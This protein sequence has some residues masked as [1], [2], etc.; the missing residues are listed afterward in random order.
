MKN[1]NKIMLLLAA[2]VMFSWTALGQGTIT[3]V[4]K[5]A[6]TG[7]ALVGTSI[8]LKGTSTGTTTGIDGRF[9]LQAPAYGQTLV[10][11]FIGYNSREITVNVTSG[12]ITNVGIIRLEGSAIGL[13][14]I[15][16]IADRAKERETP[17]AFSNLTKKQIEDQLGSQD[18]PLVLNTTP[19]VYATMQGGGAGDARV[20]VRGFNQRNVAIMINGVPINDMENGWV[21]WSNWDGIGDAT[22]SIQVQ[23]GLS[24][25]NLATPSIGGTMNVITSPAEATAGVTY[26]QEFGS[27]RFYK[28]TVFGHTG[29]I[30]GKYAISAGVVRKVGEG[31]IDATYTDAWAYYLGASYNINKKNRIEFY[32]MGAPQRHGQNSYKQNIAAYD[33]NFA[34]EID[35][36]DVDAIAKFKQS[37][38]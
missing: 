5:D 33:S 19:S 34:K 13:G 30:D 38:S 21:Y 17:V 22:S 4:V 3:G 28:S 9:S 25:V 29:L 20:N 24:A 1:I 35:G 27:G 7:E 15:S 12:Q 14:G 6:G 18:I 11:S 37:T 23:R 8:A 10:I 36:Y 2:F 26:K 16:I 32:A 31:V